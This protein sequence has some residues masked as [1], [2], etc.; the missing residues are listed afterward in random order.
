MPIDASG[1]LPDGRQFEDVN[2]LRALL[3][4]HP[5]QFV[6]TLTENLLTYALGRGLEPFDMPA[7]R[8]IVRDAAAGRLSLSVDP[9]GYCQQLSVPVAEYEHGAP[10]CG[11]SGSVIGA[12][13]ERMKMRV[14]R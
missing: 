9:V 3:M 1:T 10:D 7:V 5:E 14:H 11:I 6:T 8:K 2:E 13:N 4:Q 12:S